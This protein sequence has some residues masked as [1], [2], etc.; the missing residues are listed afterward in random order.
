MNLTGIHL[1]SYWMGKNDVVALMAE[2]LQ[3]VS[4]AKLVDTRIYENNAAN[5]YEE[6]TPPG[7]TFAIRWI[8]E[9]KLQTLVRK[10]KPD[11]LI[12][13]AG[14]MALK[15]STALWL[16]KQ[17][18][19]SVGI[20]LSD[21]DVFSDNG[22]VYSHLFDLYYTNS[23][24]SL[25]AQYPPESKYRWL[26][27]AASPKLHKPLSP[28]A[29]AYDIVVVGHARP[30]RLKT[31]AMLSKHFSVATFGTGW[32]TVDNTVHGEAHARAINSGKIYLSFAKTYA[33]YSNV[34]VGLFEAAAC[35]SCIVTEYMPEIEN[36][37]TYGIDIVGYTNETTLQE[38]IRYYLDHPLAREW[39]ATNCYQRTLSEHTWAHRWKGVL[40]DIQDVRKSRSIA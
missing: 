38:A 28:K 19:I 8:N 20:E 22:R 12:L 4:R 36:L 18:V 37:F 30:E 14:G 1:G 2:E 16:K 32:T 34:K 7:Q 6:V 13:N 5:W 24:Y 26:P 3:K 21:P 31:V 9:V 11:Y 23:L 17:G 25:K 33:G 10:Y 27:F 35:K 29:K 40:N 15:P 39:I